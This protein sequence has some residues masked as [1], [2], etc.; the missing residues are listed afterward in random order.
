[1]ASDLKSDLVL[2]A[3]Q[4]RPT[5]SL[6]GNPAVAQNTYIPHFTY[7]SKL[8]NTTKT[9]ITEMS[10]KVIIL[11]QHYCCI[12]FVHMSEIGVKNARFK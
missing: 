3:F 5:V 1:M 6:M 11:G 4:S 2:T 10:G 12:F 9:A 7:Y 8:T